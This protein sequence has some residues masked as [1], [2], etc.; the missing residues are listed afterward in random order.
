MVEVGEAPI[1]LEREWV[2]EVGPERAGAGAIIERLAEGVIQQAGEAPAEALFERCLERLEFGV[3]AETKLRQSRKRRRIGLTAGE[4]TM[5]GGRSVD[6]GVRLDSLQQ[7]GTLGA[8]I[9]EPGQPVVMQLALDS[10][11][12]ALDVRILPV[13]RV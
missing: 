7:S 8:G 1:V 12:P 11:I 2:G 4:I 5:R 10:E 3:S 6:S 13:L 9:C